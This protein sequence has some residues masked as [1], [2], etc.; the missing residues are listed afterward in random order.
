MITRR[1]RMITL[2]NTHRETVDELHLFTAGRRRF[3]A[4][5][6]P[7][8][9][10]KWQQTKQRTLEPCPSAFSAVRL[11]YGMQVLQTVGVQRQI[12]SGF[13]CRGATNS[14]FDTVTE[15]NWCSE[16]VSEHSFLTAHQLTRGHFVNK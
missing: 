8:V 14:N 2:Q 13:E 12:S 1:Q 6:P 11:C 4:N 5:F 16:P 9:V 15:A 7:S 3:G 10:A